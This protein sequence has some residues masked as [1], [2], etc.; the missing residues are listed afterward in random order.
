MSAAIAT[1]SIYKQRPLEEDLLATGPLRTKS[2]KRKAKRDEDEPSYVDSIASRKI[3]KIG[4]ELQ[5]EDRAASRATQPNSAFTFESRLATTSDPDP[6]EEEK[7]DD[8]EAWGGED[9]G[10]TEEAV[11]LNNLFSRLCID[12][13][14][15]IDPHDLDLFHKFIPAGEEPTL[16]LKATAA[17][18]QE[19]GTNLA[20]LILRQIAAHEAA[21][22]NETEVLGGGP[23][24][25]A[26]EIPA[27]VVEVYTK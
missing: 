15:E 1:A 16:D 11:S 19:Q 3:L 18:S 14:Q 13:T 8:E 9:G 22:A 24:E 5:E 26:I 4:Q 12:Q 2:K 20:D 10:V 17:S 25:E 21:Q 6:E 7:Y 23:P 27:K